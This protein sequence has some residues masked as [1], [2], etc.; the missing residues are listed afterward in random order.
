MAVSWPPQTADISLALG[1]GQ[2][3]CSLQRRDAALTHPARTPIFARFDF[4]S[5]GRDRGQALPLFARDARW[6]VPPRERWLGRGS[7]EELPAS[8]TTTPSRTQT[9]GTSDTAASDIEPTA[10]AASGVCPVKQDVAGPQ[11]E[12]DGVD[13]KGQ[14]LAEAPGLRK[15]ERLGA[16]EGYR[17]GHQADRLVSLEGEQPARNLSQLELVEPGAAGRPDAPME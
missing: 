13:P 17:V 3:M 5:G 6:A 8:A 1:S 2:I 12:Y 10:F 16:S 11:A 15:D 7:I 14:H 4:P 9:V